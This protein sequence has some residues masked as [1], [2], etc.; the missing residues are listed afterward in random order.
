MVS[1]YNK[2]LYE[3]NGLEKCSNLV[4]YSGWPTDPVTGFTGAAANLI[5]DTVGNIAYLTPWAVS[6]AL[7]LPVLGGQVTGYLKA[8]FDETTSSNV[9]AAKARYLADAYLAQANQ[10]KDETSLYKD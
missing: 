1:I 8:K 5:S 10:L 2:H 7:G 4:K 3:D 9:D 6:L